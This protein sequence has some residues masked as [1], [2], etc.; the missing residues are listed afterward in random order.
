MSVKRYMV[1]IGSTH[2]GDPWDRDAVVLAS[3][4]EALERDR[5]AL[6]ADAERLRFM[7]EQMGTMNFVFFRADEAAEAYYNIPIP[8]DHYLDQLRAQIDAA[9]SPSSAGD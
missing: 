1:D 4:Y 7:A 5:D 6:K 2:T 9:R 3:D 8:P